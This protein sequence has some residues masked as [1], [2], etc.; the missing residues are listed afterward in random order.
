MIYRKTWFDYVL[1][2]VYAGLCVMLLAFTGYHIYASYV[3]LPMARLGAFLVFPVLVCVYF[4]LR[5]ACQ[6]VGKKH[7]LSAHSASMLEA[8]VVS[9]SFIFGL[10]IRISRLLHT[11]PEAVAG[12]YYEQALVRAGRAAAPLT[13]G[14]SDLYVR[15]L[16]VVFSFLGNGPA[17]AMLFQVFLQLIAMALGFCAVKKAAGRMAAGISLLLLAFAGTFL[18]KIPVVDPECLF[19]VLYLFGLFL[20][21]S[22]LKAVLRGQL[23]KGCWPFAFLLGTVL[24]VLVYLELWAAT[25]LLFLIGFFT[26]KCQSAEDRK[27]CT[28]AF[29]V[30]LFSCVAG[31]FGSAAMD[32]AIS[33]TG[34]LRC[35]SGWVSLYGQTGLKGRLFGA[36]SGRYVFWAVL[37]LAA[38]FLVFEFVREGKEQDYTLWLLPCILSTPVMLSDFGRISFGSV[39]MFLWSAMAGLGVK[40]CVSG[41]QAVAVLKK[42]EKINESAKEFDVPLSKEE[43]PRF[44]ENPLPLP[45]KHVK[46]EMDYDY[47][48]PEAD[49]HYQ[50]EIAQEDDFDL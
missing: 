20:I 39:A 2:A 5:L 8:L 26:G 29:F 11:P 18:D 50:I 49:M 15:C 47:E 38:A 25:L 19:L 43:K 10:L 44:I 27:R 24:G 4:A 30:T 33:G 13:H 37:F 46:R 21:V 7:G 12:V 32:C 41:G 34:F 14:V 23:G 17:S 3:G 42:I 36:V 35:L 40:N 45:K 31:F 9:V 16:T 22:F 6:A 48:V 28:A 1:W